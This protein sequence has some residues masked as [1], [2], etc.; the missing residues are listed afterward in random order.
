MVP[1]DQF[2]RH[3]QDY[4]VC[5]HLSGDHSACEFKGWLSRAEMQRQEVVMLKVL[6]VRAPFADLRPMDDLMARLDNATA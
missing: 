4:Y 2:E 3:R 6:T 5:A 1:R